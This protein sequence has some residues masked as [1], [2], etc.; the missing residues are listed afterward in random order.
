MKWSKYA[1]LMLVLLFSLGLNNEATAQRTKKEK[2]K[3][4]YKQEKRKKEYK[5][6]KRKRNVKK[7]NNNKKRRQH[8]HQ[9]HYRS[10]PKWGRSVNVAP[11]N[12][13]NINFRGTKY[14]YH[15]GIYYRPVSNG[16]VIAEAP[17]GIRL[18]TLPPA[19]TVVHH[20]GNPYYYYYGSFY[21]KVPN[22]RE[23]EVIAPPVG[24]RI[25]GLPEGARTLLIDGVNYFVLDEIYYKEIIVTINRDQ[26]VWYEVVGKR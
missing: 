23:Y 24:A 21:D 18:R 11:R 4:E 15:N 3:R 16:Y 13:V 6:E 25:P 10:Q 22:S 26:E 20:G 5:Q 8:V 1:V 7:A 2:I 9:T 17:V 14:R 19:H 12:S